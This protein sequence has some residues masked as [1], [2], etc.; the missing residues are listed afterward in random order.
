MH[1]RLIL[2]VAD[3]NKEQHVVLLSQNQFKLHCAAV[4]QLS[5]MKTG[6]KCYPVSIH[7]LHMSKP[8]RSSWRAEK[9]PFVLFQPGVSEW[10]EVLESRVGSG[11]RCEQEGALLGARSWH[12]EVLC[13]GCVE[14][15]VSCGY[16]SALSGMHLENPPS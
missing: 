5:Q 10:A 3:P 4:Q 7:L 15:F 2:P 9:F 12:G 11:G 8:K 16:S 6:I 13:N 1:F 14:R